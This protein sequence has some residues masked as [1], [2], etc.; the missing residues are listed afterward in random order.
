M[1][2]TN[3]ANADSEVPVT[4]TEGNLPGNE[5][6]TSEQ[7]PTESEHTELPEKG[8]DDWKNRYDGTAKAHKQL[9]EEHQRVVET[10]VKLVEKNPDLL[11]DLAE[12]DPALADKVTQKIHGKSY[13]EYKKNL[14]LEEIREENP[15]RYEQEKRLRMLEERE[16]ARAE[17]AQKSFLKEK[18]IK[19]NEFDPAYKSVKAQL[20]VF[21][22]KFV[23]ENPERAW[24]MAYNL[25]FPAKADTGEEK[26]ASF[27]AGNTTKR[28]GNMSAKI[29]HSGSN[30]S[31][32]AQAFSSRFRE[33]TA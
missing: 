27:L 18:G 30:K 31:P 1:D 33:L 17:N 19:E 5:E 8:Q 3:S 24:E 29:D 2:I 20:D 10:N 22:P 25:A 7:K 28:G 9:S 23:E 4:P 11:E 12:T 16:Q 26:K 13:S 6:S 15:E 14:E 21:N 32:E